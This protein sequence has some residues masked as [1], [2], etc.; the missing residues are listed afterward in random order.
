VSS[1]LY[2]DLSRG[3]VVRMPDGHLYSVVD[4]QLKTPGNLPSKLWL[5][6]KNLKTGFVNDQRVHPDDKVEKAD[7]ETRAMQYLYRDADEYIF[8]DTETF[9]QFHLRA[10]L[11]GE[12]ILYLKESDKTKITFHDGNPLSMELP[13]SVELRVKE[14]EPAIKGST[15][16]AQYKPATLETGL[17][18]SVPPF[19]G[20]GEMILVDTRSGEY[21]SRVKG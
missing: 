20:E 9:E 13:A 21:L 2:R 8:M 16:T 7:L 17:K 18:V 4:R 3:M 6:L 1:I 19:V 11:V 12:Q 10:D 5:T 14:T 15:A